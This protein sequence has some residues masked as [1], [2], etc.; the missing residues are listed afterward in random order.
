MNTMTEQKT[1]L[2]Y[3]RMK[4]SVNGNPR[5]RVVFTDGTIAPMMPDSGTS[6]E[7]GN[8]DMREGCRVEVDFTPSGKIRWMRSAK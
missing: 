3:E 7:I 4:S 5:Y 6:Y 1:I 2:S 8:S